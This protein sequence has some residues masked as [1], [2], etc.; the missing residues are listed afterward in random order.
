MS[1]PTLRERVPFHG[2]LVEADSALHNRHCMPPGT[3]ESWQPNDAYASTE[4]CTKTTTYRE[5][6][7]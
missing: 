5:L 4:S 6:V 1:K 7:T 3:R 2:N